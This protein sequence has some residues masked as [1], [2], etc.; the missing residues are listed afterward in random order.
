[1]LARRGFAGGQVAFMQAFYTSDDDQA[2]TLARMRQESVPFVLLVEDE[3]P[4]FEG[5]FPKVLAHITSRYEVMAHVP[6]EGMQGVRVLVER[7]RTRNGRDAETGWPCF[8]S[9]NVSTRT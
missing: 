9:R 6:V 8:K 4:A 5:G 7:Q 1:V 2:L 3:Q